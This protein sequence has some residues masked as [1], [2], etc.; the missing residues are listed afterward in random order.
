[1]GGPCE[2]LIRMVRN[3]LEPLLMKVGNQLDDET[4]RTFLTKV[5]CIVNSRSLS[6]DYLS[7]AETPEPSTPN[8]LLTMKPKRVLPPPGEF[9]RPDVYCRRRWRRVQFC[10]NEFWLR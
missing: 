9:Q 4:L 8:H 6:V 10:A 5:E 2:R 7:D 3:A 1:M